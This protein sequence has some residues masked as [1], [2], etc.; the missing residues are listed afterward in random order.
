[1]DNATIRVPDDVWKRLVRFSEGVVRFSVKFLDDQQIPISNS[2]GFL[3]VRQKFQ[4]RPSSSN[5]SVTAGVGYSVNAEVSRK[6]PENGEVRPITLDDPYTG[7]TTNTF[8][9]SAKFDFSQSFRD[10]A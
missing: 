10:R 1:F 2:D 8:D 4:E 3:R 9:G 5:W 7:G 6:R